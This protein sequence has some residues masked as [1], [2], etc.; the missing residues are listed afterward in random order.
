MVDWL[1]G[2]SSQACRCCGRLSDLGLFWTFICRE[3]FAPAASYV[4][5]RVLARRSAVALTRSEGGSFLDEDCRLGRPR[6]VRLTR[7]QQAEAV[8]LLARLLLDAARL[9]E[10]R[11]TGRPAGRLR[12]AA[13][14]PARR[15]AS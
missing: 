2:A 14:N 8:E 9:E 10:G 3:V 7:G 11:R 1:V 13:P 15:H 12:R 5:P 4:S 6:L